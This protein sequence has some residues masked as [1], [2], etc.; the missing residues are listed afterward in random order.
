M[1]GCKYTKILIVITKPQKIV[2]FI[3]QEKSCRF[4]TTKNET[5]KSIKK[6]LILF[7]LL[8]ISAL[9]LA[10]GDT[11]GSDLPKKSEV[12]KLQIIKKQSISLRNTDPLLSLTYAKQSLALAQSIADKKEIA[13]AY[14][15]IGVAN[16]LMGNPDA[17]MSNYLNAE[18]FYAE[19][20]DII[21]TG[22]IASNI[23]II[24]QEK[25]KYAAA[26]LQYN[27]SLQISLALSN[28]ESISDD[29]IN[30]GV[31]YQKAGRFGAALEYFT[32]SLQIESRLNKPERIAFCYH[33]LAVV[34]IDLLKLDK[35]IY[36]NDQ[37]MKL[38]QKCN[39]NYYISQC[40]DNKGYILFK[41]KDYSN[42]LKYYNQALL[43]KEDLNDK[44]GM[45]SVLG[46]IG[47]I[48]GAKGFF[49]KANDYYFQALKIDE[50]LEDRKGIA[51]SY[52]KIGENLCA[53]K[54]Y[55]KSINYLSNSLALSIG[56]N[57]WQ[58]IAT[59]YQKLAE[60]YYLKGD[61]EKAYTNLY[62]FNQYSDSINAEK[63]I[64]IHPEY[65]EPIVNTVLRSET[66]K[67]E[68]KNNYLT[69][70]IVVMSL[71]VIGIFGLYLREKKNNRF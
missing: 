36:F 5:L 49:E 11:I 38:Y 67:L 15:N 40:I 23:G 58:E 14:K 51:I 59:N 12:E 68:K 44:S 53:M 55:E 20:D 45:S 24:F 28:K 69:S 39:N 60:G 50:E 35:A 26:I 48:Y 4:V 25:G 46:N 9:L 63:N 7:F 57:A 61:F 10:N 33:N 1:G 19:T 71:S 43:L 22:A 3:I 41:I 17:A 70:A 13:E 34:Y 65:A 16:Y 6:Y 2:S 27:K 54:E 18:K 47:A 64:D 8:F 52:T 62:K 32:K 42:A 37:A 30:M 29:Y 56:I 21:G 31:T 66:L